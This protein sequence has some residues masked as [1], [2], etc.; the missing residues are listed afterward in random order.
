M[1]SVLS[2]N[3]NRQ[4]NAIVAHARI[5]EGEFHDLRRTCLAT[6]LSNGLS[7]YDVMNLAGHAEFETTHQFYLAVREDL[8]RRAG[9]VSAEALNSNF[10]AH[11]LRARSG[12]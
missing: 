7:E 4:F 8:S 3:F 11:L 5:D 6:W 10:V 1:E 9:A 12:T 2:T